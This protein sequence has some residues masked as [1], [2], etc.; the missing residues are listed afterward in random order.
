M[1]CLWFLTVSWILC[2]P[3]AWRPRWRRPG[4]LAPPIQQHPISS[5]RSP[6]CD[7]MDSRGRGR[8]WR[9]T[10]ILVLDVW[11]IPPPPSA[12]QSGFTALEARD[13]NAYCSLRGPS[14]QALLAITSQEFAQ[15]LVAQLASSL[16]LSSIA[17]SAASILTA[18]INYTTDNLTQFDMQVDTYIG[19]F[20][21]P[22]IL[23]SSLVLA[24]SHSLD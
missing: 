15:Q 10:L 14:V 13:K 5:S 6:F 12:A 11:S 1:K 3:W 4:E 22:K 20:F 23:I 18:L 17:H 19:S 7:A 16:S 24:L 21:V 2:I 8:I 9:G